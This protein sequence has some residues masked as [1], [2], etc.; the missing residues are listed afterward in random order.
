MMKEVHGM[1]L[2]SAVN[3][4]K[5]GRI[6]TAAEYPSVTVRVRNPADLTAA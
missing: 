4:I 2:D 6:P 1:D 5:A 3:Q